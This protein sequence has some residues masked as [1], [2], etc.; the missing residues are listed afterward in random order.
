[1]G[2]L[3][4]ARARVE[5][6]AR[7][8]G[9]TNGELSRALDEHLAGC[10]AC[11]AHERSLAIVRRRLRTQPAQPVPDL[12]PAILARVATEEREARRRAR[13]R[14]RL[15]VGSIAAAAAALV[16]LGASLPF[17]ER[18]PATADASEITEGIRAAARTLRAFRAGFEITERG[19]HPDVSVRRFT[20]EIA[21]RAP[22][23]FVLS[24]R[25]HTR[26]PDPN[27]WPENDYDVIANPR[28]WWIRE[29]TTCPTA[30]LP[31]CGVAAPTEERTVWRRQPFD[32]ASALPTDIVIPLETLSSSSGFEVLGRDQ[33]LGRA[34]YR[35]A[36]PY[37]QA[38]PL[39]M[40]LQAGGSWRP[41]RPFDR[42]QIWVD[43]RTWFPLRYD[44]I[45]RGVRLLSVRAT[46]FEQPRHL[47]A[48]L[49]EPPRSG[50]PRS[51]GFEVRPF[52]RIRRNAPELEVDLAPYRAGVACDAAGPCPP[53]A[54]RGQRVLAWAEG[55][56]FLK[57]AADRTRP[58]SAL[59]QSKA[60]EVALDD[61]TY[62]YYEPGTDTFKRRVDVYSDELHVHLES[63]LPRHDLLEVAASLDIDGD[64]LPRVRREGGLR[65]E[66]VDVDEALP[67]SFARSPAYL[68]SDY[69][70]SAAFTSRSPR[71]RQSVT[72][73]YRRAQA[74][75]DGIGVRITQ[76]RPVR[77]L[78]PTS[79]SIRAVRI[80][81]A[82][83][84][85]AA[86]RGELEWI[87]DGTYR[88]VAAPSFGLPTALRIARS[89]R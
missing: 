77:L 80:G 21:F 51:G 32:G 59:Y 14:A 30:A 10:E 63:N 42:V 36:L 37:R 47:D 3:V 15:R 85:W 89:L 25:D 60:E 17:S 78:P 19:W 38:V 54:G 9:E 61:G 64:R 45:G 12:A 1:M 68:P 22:E 28:R 62:A 88:A 70:A 83:G 67:A 72:V 31:G 23:S 66:R 43:A 71:G 81:D 27:L 84:R 79:E 76:A 5:L 18:P 57:M 73:Y 50:F 69:R 41:F 55:M 13:W 34:A 86:E 48:K 20:A 26:Y 52:E 40:A 11:R 39:V 46:S 49:F 58:S 44:V 56:T 65:I 87:D 8:D 35:V 6:S 4:C 33:V 29:P 2:D 82:E 74:E 24:V 53:P 7:L 16:V 75:Y